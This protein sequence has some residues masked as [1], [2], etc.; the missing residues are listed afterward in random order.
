[1]PADS[2][3]APGRIKFVAYRLIVHLL[4]LPTSPHGDAVTFGYKFESSFGGDLHPSDTLR[5]LAHW[6]VRLGPGKLEIM[7][8]SLFKAI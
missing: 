3:E 2:P 8:F 5:S 4:L 7:S 1:L 6:Q